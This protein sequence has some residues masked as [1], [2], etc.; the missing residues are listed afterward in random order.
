MSEPA[1]ICVVSASNQNAYFAEILAAFAVALREMGAE[2]EESVDCFPP[3]AED[4]VY[5]F[6]PHEYNPLVRELARPSETQLR[7]TV[8]LCT[9][10]PGT[11]WFETGAE[12]AARAGAVVDI[13][14]L[15]ARELRRR[16][17]AAEHA[18]LG[19]VPAWDA[20]G[21]R[22]N[23]GRGIDLVFLGAHTERRARVLARCAPALERRRA[24][25]HLVEA[26]RPHVV[27]SPSLIAGERRSRLLANAKVLLSVHQ[28]ELA[29]M[30]WHRVLTAVANGCVVLSEHSLEIDPLEPGRHFVSARYEDL[31]LVLEGLLDDADRLAAIRR[32]AYTLVRERMPM[33]RA[34]AAVLRATE[35]VAGAALPQGASTA[36]PGVPLP[37]SLPERKPEWEARSEWLG[38]QLPVRRALKELLTRTRALEQRLGELTGG[39]ASAVEAVEELGPDPAE[40]RISVLLTVHDYADLVGDALRSLAHGTLRD[41]EV[42]VVDDGSS[43]GSADAVREACSELRSLPVRLIRRSENSGRPAV[44]RNL[45]LAHARADLLFVLDADN[46]VLP[47]GLSLLARA[48]DEE[49]EA[50]FA[51]GILQTFDASGPRG[52]DSWLE[53]SAERLRHGNF[54][55]AMALVRRSALHAVGDYPTEPALAGW[56]D[57]A[58]WVAMADAGLHGA[59]VPEL[60]GRYRLSPHSTISLA[61]VD[62]SRAWATLLRRYPVLTRATA[63]EESGWRPGG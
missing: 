21:G 15:A 61:D 4:L 3:P 52:L 8:A 26:V 7:R 42:V 10:Q 29:Y 22:E 11:N 48:L 14:A 56:E 37:M 24:A 9:E 23:G 49:P 45:A 63:E 20:W 13:N 35:R 55:D 62:H 1:R 39:D 50:A 19:Y 16:G 30:E 47:Q 2:V 51:Y 40:P 54:V 28:Q 5:L 33:T 6:I 17:I 43:D 46:T 60:V 36:P 57:F 34:A 44:A 27:G 12:I 58:V 38:E 53:W 25:I 41:L 59:R 32:D 31:P 18:P